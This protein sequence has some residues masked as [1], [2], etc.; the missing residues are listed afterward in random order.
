MANIQAIVIQL[1]PSLSGPAI[2]V[3]PLEIPRVGV[4][5]TSHA[6][7]ADS[8]DLLFIN[9]FRSSVRSV[10]SD[11]RRRCAKITK[12]RWSGVSPLDRVDRAC[13]AAAAAMCDGAMTPPYRHASCSD[14]NATCRMRTALLLRAWRPSVH[15]SVCLFV[16]VR[17]STNSEKLRKIGPVYSEI[18]GWIRHFLSCNISGLCSD[19]ISATT[20][21]NGHLT[22]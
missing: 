17:V 12:M 3:D 16:T 15:L 1:R 4:V 14:F 18:F 20:S 6:T 8:M 21:R 13:G 22:W 9:P 2:S 19:T 11:H 7:H 5:W 10:R